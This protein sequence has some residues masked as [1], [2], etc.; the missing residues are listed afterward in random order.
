[1][2]GSGGQGVVT[3]G[4]LLAVAGMN[5][6]K[7]IS[8]FPTY[9]AEMRGGYAFVTVVISEEEIPSPIVSRAEVG[10]FLNPFAYDYLKPMVINSG[11]IIFNSDLIRIKKGRKKGNLFPVSADT[12]AQRVGDK[13]SANMVIAGFLASKAEEFPNLITPFPAL[14]SLQ[15]SLPVIFPDKENVVAINRKA[16]LSGYDAARSHVF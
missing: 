14:K 9:G 1:L 11:V 12:I 15:E 5:E 10:V 8:C 7:E 3:L 4:K 6:G 13:R 16:L 2:G